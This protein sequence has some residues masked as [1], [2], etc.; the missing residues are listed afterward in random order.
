MLA[1]II[2]GELD[3]LETYAPEVILDSIRSLCQQAVKTEEAEDAEAEPRRFRSMLI[4]DAS[5]NTI[6]ALWGAPDWQPP[7]D[8]GAAE[9]IVAD[10]T[11]LADAFLAQH[12]HDAGRE[13]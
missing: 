1:E 7:L 9:R 10:A 4:W 2:L 12:P 6:A 3:E 8:A 11:I 5:R 13:V